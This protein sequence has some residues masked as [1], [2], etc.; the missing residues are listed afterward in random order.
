MPSST[1][2]SKHKKDCFILGGGIQRK[3]ERVKDCP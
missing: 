3:G 2:V 1:S